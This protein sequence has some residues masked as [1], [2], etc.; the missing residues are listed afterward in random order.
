MERTGGEEKEEKVKG[1]GGIDGRRTGRRRSLMIEP[2][3]LN[4]AH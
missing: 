1:G 3:Q 4:L 2:M